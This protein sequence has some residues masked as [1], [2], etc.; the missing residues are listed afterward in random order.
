[1][2]YSY[3]LL[4]GDGTTT[5]FSFNFGYLA[6]AH[7][8]ASVDTVETS[9]DWVGDFSIQITPA[10][11]AGTVVEIRRR[12]P[13]DE[14]IVDWTDGTVLNAGD[15]DLNTLFALFAAQEAQDGVDASV[16][17]NAEGVWDGQGR[18]TTN[19]ADPTDNTGLVTKGY[20]DDVYTPQLDQKIAD[21][22]A[23]ID[24]KVTEATTQASN[25][26]SSAT[27]AQGYAVAADSSADLAAALLAIFKG[28][29]LGAQTEAPTVDGNGNSITA[30]DLYF[31]TTLKMMKVYSG[32]AWV[33]AGSTVEGVVEIPNTVV[34]A[35]E[36]Q[37]SIPVPNGYDPGMILVVLNGLNVW[38]PEV[39]TSNGTDIVFNTPLSAGD[40]VT[41]IAFG[42]FEA[43][44]AIPATGSVTEDKIS[45]TPSEIDAINFKLGVRKVVA[46]I[47]ALQAVDKTK[48]T[49]VFVQGY[50]APGDGGGGNYYLDSTDTTSPSNG[51]TT[52]VATDGGRWKLIHQG[53]VSVRQFGAK[54]DGTTDDQPK[55]QAAID[56]F[57]TSGGRVWFPPGSYAIGGSGL[58]LANE[59]NGFNGT[60]L[61]GAGQ[62]VELKKIGGANALLSILGARC[63]VRGL[64][65]NGNGVAGS[66]LYLNTLWDGQPTVIENCAFVSTTSEGIYNNDG[67]SYLIRNCYFLGTGQWAVLSR[68]NFMNSSFSANFVQG[69]GGLKFGSATQQAEGVRV[70]DNTLLVSGGSGIGVEVEYGL[71]IIIA[72]NIIDQVTNCSVRIRNNSSYVKILGNWLAGGTGVMQTVSIA[73]NANC[74]TVSNN[75]FEGG[76]QDQLFAVAG[77]LGNIQNLL[78]QNN[79]FNNTSTG[80]VAIYMVRI[81]RAVISGN[82][83]RGSGAESIFWNEGQHGIVSQNVCWKAPN[84]GTGALNLNNLGW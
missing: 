46:N 64:T 20:F 3:V 1:M 70:V 83:V 41:W 30:G 69:S 16:S 6:K 84:I 38:A 19:F 52:I 51:G 66:A 49:S 22:N 29:Y 65:F 56:I 68:N 82:S 75:T 77:V 18:S 44:N 53:S 43:A 42:A 25:A 21:A 15:M 36:G 61:E 71:E 9:F 35:S 23:A 31:D 33:N 27:T 48:Y 81:T 62:G 7:I 17:Q 59:I 76:G 8:H 12:T 54:G 24:T 73:D 55:V 39:D 67:D 13:L 78:I 4:P 58:T 11:A 60:I 80:R 14:P 47:S 32:T 37:T 63:T 10:P 34:V 45:S 2:P 5:N 74:I 28:Q 50:Y 40:E 57:S 26:A 79:I 72:N